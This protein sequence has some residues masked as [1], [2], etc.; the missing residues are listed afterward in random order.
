MVSRV[1]QQRRLRMELRRLRVDAGRTQKAVADSLGWSTSK[2]IRIE[3]GAVQVAT[4]DVRALL[5][6]YDVKED[7]ERILALTRTD[8]EAWWDEYR[9]YFKQQFIDFIAYEDSAFRIRQFI[10]SIVPG[11]LQT[12]EYI[13]AVFASYMLD[14]E[15]MERAVR[16]RLR[17]QQ[18]LAPENGR[19]FWF[20]MDESVLHRWIGGPEVARRQLL[21]LKELAQRPNI[22]I[23]VV[24][25]SVG[26]HPGMF[27]S[28]TIYEFTGE[29]ED[30]VVNIEDANRP[31]QIREE[32]EITSKYIEDHLVLEEMA[33]PENELDK[34]ID[35]VLEG[36]R[37]NT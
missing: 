6:Y 21:K 15:A 16:V 18:V 8:E 24:P 32:P 12:E 28:F 27:D 30:S 2:V 25:F 37:L 3:T 31:A 26:M 36:I 5:Q 34:V 4:S 13:R 35:S 17:R 33:S 20:L 1:M 19:Q 29:D 11:L 10:G 22:S 9:S 7:A 14:D 23:R